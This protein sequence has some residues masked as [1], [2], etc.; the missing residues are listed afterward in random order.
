MSKALLEKLLA[1]SLRDPDNGGVLS[2]PVK[3]VVLGANSQMPQP[4]SLLRCRSE[5]PLPWSWTGRH[6]L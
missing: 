5:N 3:I 1:G 6:A 2:V 4:I